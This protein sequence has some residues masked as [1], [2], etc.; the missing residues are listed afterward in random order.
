MKIR[1]IFTAARAALAFGCWDLSAL[2][3]R[4]ETLT[5]KSD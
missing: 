5:P 2:D 3:G 4:V 1:T